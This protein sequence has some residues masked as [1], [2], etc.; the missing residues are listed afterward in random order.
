MELFLGLVLGFFGGL[1]V[2]FGLSLYWQRQAARSQPLPTPPPPGQGGVN[3]LDTILGGSNPPAATNSTADRVQE[4]R[5][6]L[7]LKFLYD[8]NKVEDAIAREREAKPDGTMQDWLE[9]AIFRW[10]RENR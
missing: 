1:A 3:L 10:E 8:E 4:L 6:N 9:A 7:R 2:G 5:Q